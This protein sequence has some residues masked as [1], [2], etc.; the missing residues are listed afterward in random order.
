MS[1]DSAVRRVVFDQQE[2]PVGKLWLR[3]LPCRRRIR[4]RR[5]GKD[6]E[7]KGRT[8]AGVALDPNAAAHQFGEP[9]ANGQP[10]AGA[11]VVASGGGIDLLE[12]FK[13]PALSIDGNANTGIADRE[14]QQPIFRIAEKLG[15]KL[16]LSRVWRL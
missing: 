16:T 5:D 7:M 9:F 14:M 4:C 6:G 12:R 13:K 1:H 3:G 11:P 15:I 8:F 10:E 2:I